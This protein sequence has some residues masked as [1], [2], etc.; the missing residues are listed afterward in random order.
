MRIY[1]KLKE[2]SQFL[3]TGIL[4]TICIASIAGLQTP[5][6][7]NNKSNTEK[8]EYFRQEQ[9]KAA[10]LDIIS[11]FP[12]FGF[13]NLIADWLFLQ[14][15]QYFGD[16]DAREVTG[17]QLV[18]EYFQAIVKRD[19][20]FVTAYNRLSTANTIFAGNPEL[21]I[22]LLDQALQSLSPQ[23]SEDTPQLWIYKGT[24][25]LLYLGNLDTAKRSYQNA[26]QWAEQ[27]NDPANQSIKRYAQRMIDFIET[28]PNTRE[29]QIGAWTLIL[30]T[31]DQAVVQKEAIKNIEALG[32]EV[33]IAPDGTIKSIRVA[34]EN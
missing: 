11:D 6:L 24:D 10:N 13:E 26:V 15:I 12:S 34:P 3:F 1:T 22:K 18:P 9:V 29:G 8:S 4:I 21:T 23:I 28:D 2:N 33:I 32:G 27:S 17:Y 30:Q 14:F 7:N 25:E 16:T 19:P 5:K 20:Y 31:T